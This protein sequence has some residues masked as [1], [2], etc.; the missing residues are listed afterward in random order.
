M[1]P[2]N[3]QRQNQKRK[4]YASEPIR[5]TEARLKG[6]KNI[7]KIGQSRTSNSQMIVAVMRIETG[8]IALT[9]GNTVSV[10]SASTVESQ[11]INDDFMYLV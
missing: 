6:S 7:F 8:E 5:P 3:I 1:T 2:G 4:K 10:A 11:L 9:L